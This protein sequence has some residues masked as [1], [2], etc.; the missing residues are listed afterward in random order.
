MSELRRVLL[1]DSNAPTG[2]SPDAAFLASRNAGAAALL[3]HHADVYRALYDRYQREGP[4]AEIDAIA[5]EAA[6]DLATVMQSLRRRPDLLSVMEVSPDVV[7]PPL[8]IIDQLLFS[9]VLL[10]D[11]E[12]SEDSKASLS[13]DA[14][15]ELLALAGVKEWLDSMH[16]ELVFSLDPAFDDSE[17]P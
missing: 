5:L 1:D 6:G 12:A 9:F 15:D 16:A 7:A 13:P 2:L 14:L 17:E 3:V 4:S 10:T 8:P 11:P